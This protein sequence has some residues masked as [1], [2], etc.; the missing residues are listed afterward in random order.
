MKL[1]SLFGARVL[2]S[3]VSGLFLLPAALSAGEHRLSVS[4]VTA[5]PGGRVEVEVRFEANASQVS[6][7]AF[8][9]DYDESRLVFD[10]TSLYPGRLRFVT[11]E[12]DEQ[13]TAASF[14]FPRNRDGEIGISVFDSRAPFEAI[15]PGPIAKISFD[16]KPGVDGFAWIRLA[17]EDPS[18]A[19]VDGN[20]VPVSFSTPIGGVAISPQRPSLAVT[21][22]PIHFGSIPTGKISLRPVVLTNAGNAPLTISRI[23]LEAASSFSIAA[24]PKDHLS[25]RPGDSTTVTLA[26]SYPIEGSFDGH[27]RIELGS[28]APSPVLIPVSGSVVL[29]GHFLYENRKL[30]P[31]VARLAGARDSRWRSTLTLHNSGEYPAGA[32]LTLRA[33]FGTS[34]EPKEISLAPGKSRHFD[35]VVTELFPE[36]TGSGMLLVDSSSEDLI[37]R[38]A[39]TNDQASGGSIGQTVPVVSWRDLFHT[40]QTAYLIGLDRTAEKRTNLALLN[41]GSEEAVIRAELVDKEGVVLGFRDYLIQPGSIMAGLD[42]FDAA[43]ATDIRNLTARFRATSENATFYVYAST[44]DNRTGSPIFQAPR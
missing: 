4:S 36:F 7:I 5:A 35:D 34:P 40:G 29:Q 27:L 16:V 39:T 31:A 21:P 13:L 38:S 25:L 32:L 2:L 33:S 6:A 14:F 17:D 42:L 12:V 43:G 23:T 26:F 28:P 8:R 10:G 22:A 15:P 1:P 9:I 20:S 18:A 19:D 30:I 3:L 11:F 37:A 24:Q 41:L 44:V